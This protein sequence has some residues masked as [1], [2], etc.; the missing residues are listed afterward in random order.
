MEQGLTEKSALRLGGA[1][2]KKKK[3]WLKN[4]QLHLMM[5]PG[6]IFILVFKYMPLGGITIAFKEFLPGKGIW[7]SPWVGLENFEYMLALPDTK[8]VLWNTLFIAAA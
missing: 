6:L 8:R 5:L 7:G 3:N 4:W 2:Q 1:G